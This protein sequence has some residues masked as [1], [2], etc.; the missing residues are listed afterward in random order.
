MKVW[1][2]EARTLTDYSALLMVNWELRRV[3]ESIE[4]VYRICYNMVRSSDVWKILLSTYQDGAWAERSCG[5]PRKESSAR[6]QSD[7]P[8]G[9]R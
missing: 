7:R 9:E 3:D 6:H 4:R 5:R 2:V 1:G 8:E